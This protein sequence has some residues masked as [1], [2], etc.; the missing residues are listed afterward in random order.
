MPIKYLLTNSTENKSPLF[1]LVKVGGESLWPELV[2]GNRYLATSLFKPNAGDYVIFKNPKNQRGVF[3]KKVK[4]ISGGSYEVSGT[5][6][7]SSSSEEFGLVS[8]ELVLGKV[9]FPSLIRL[10]PSRE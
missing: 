6:P 8:K 5:V 2:P 1:F 3:V 9:I 7:W 4:R 10:S